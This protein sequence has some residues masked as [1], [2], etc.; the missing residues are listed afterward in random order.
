MKS[1]TIEIFGF[2]KEQLENKDI[3]NAVLKP[4]KIDWGILNARNGFKREIVELP[5]E[6]DIFISKFPICKITYSCEDKDYHYGFC[7]C[8][9]DAWIGEDNQCC[10]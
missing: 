1:Q 10:E 2:T 8:C 3:R 5:R 6:N 9:S 4:I 7:P